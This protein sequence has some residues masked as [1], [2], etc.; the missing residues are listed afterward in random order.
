MFN[1]GNSSS[2]LENAS[3]IIGLLDVSTKKNCFALHERNTITVYPHQEDIHCTRARSCHSKRNS[4]PEQLIYL[5][6]II[7][8]RLQ[9]Y[10]AEKKR[11][12]LRSIC[13]PANIG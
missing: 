4:R 6:Y 13:I 11:L 8:A 9:I 7:Y 1:Y 10:K 12:A 5:S 3:S 2:N